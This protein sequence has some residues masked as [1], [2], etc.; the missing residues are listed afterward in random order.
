MPVVHH[1]EP[2]TFGGTGT[3]Y[4]DA[5]TVTTPDQLKAALQQQPPPPR[6]IVES[7]TLL[8]LVLG[9]LTLCAWDSA[10]KFAME[11]GYGITTDWSL[12][13][14]K[15]DGHLEFTPPMERVPHKPIQAG[16]E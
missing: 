5:V 14:N 9:A 6:I 7:K 13:R 11:R 15:I 1:L 8:W 4:A 2:I 10:V 3:F 16:E 12:G